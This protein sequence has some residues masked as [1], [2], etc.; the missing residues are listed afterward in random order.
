MDPIVEIKALM[1]NHQLNTQKTQL[2]YLQQQGPSINISI[3][4]PPT[5]TC[6]IVP[7]TANCIAYSQ[8]T[9]LNHF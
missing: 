4:S 3:Y 9:N 6:Y 8:N 2:V 5:Q 7:S 1:F